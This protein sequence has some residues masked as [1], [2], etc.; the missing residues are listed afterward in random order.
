MLDDILNTID[1]VIAF[2]NVP[3]VRALS[4]LFAGISLAVSIWLFRKTSRLIETQ[5]RHL[6]LDQ[7]R[8]VDEMQQYGNA[9]LLN[10]E[11]NRR[12]IK[13][14]FGYESDDDVF[15]AYTLFVILNPLYVAWRSA[16]EDRVAKE[17]FE[18]IRSNLLSN[19]TGD[20]EWLLSTLTKRGYSPQFVD[21]CSEWQ[22]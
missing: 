21:T 20:R 12:V 19:F 8:F 1:A 3:W 4:V 2:L 6:I 9:I 11:D 14:M 13:E 10:N 16:N 7:T 18:A 15:R 5:S 22:A 17:A